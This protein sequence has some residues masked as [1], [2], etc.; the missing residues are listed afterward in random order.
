[1][2]KS[3]ILLFC[4]I[5]L[6]GCSKKNNEIQSV[7]D[8]KLITKIDT[9]KDYIYEDLY[10]SLVVNNKDYSLTIPTINLNSDDVSNINLEI[11]NDVINSSKKYKMDNNNLISGNVIYFDYYIFDDYLSLCEYSN[12]YFNNSMGEGSVNSYIIDLKTGA[13]LSK[14]DILNIYGISDED[15]LDYILDNVDSNDKDYVIMNIKN[16]GYTL[17]INSDKKLVIYYN[18]ISDDEYKLKELVYEN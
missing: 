8:Q 7:N 15:I 10:R 14:D 18:E 17:F 13:R 1:M 16:D 12:Y 5:S 6:C 3:L 9:T 11:K 2:K 4:L